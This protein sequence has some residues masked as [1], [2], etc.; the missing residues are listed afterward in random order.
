MK[1]DKKRQTGE[2][3]TADV[4][5]ELV[6]YIKD[7]QTADI[8]PSDLNDQ[9]ILSLP[10]TIWGANLDYEK[11]CNFNLESNEK[12][13]LT[14]MEF[15]TKDGETVPNCTLR[16]YDED[17][18][19]PL[20]EISQNNLWTGKKDSDVGTNIIVEINNDNNETQ[21]CMVYVSGTII[22]ED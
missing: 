13:R 15:N 6:N 22:E 9:V 17:R 18:G 20:Q 1:W 11:I 3:I 19:L 21:D 5:N 8:D 14:R 7:L 16:V 4:W 12:F 2:N 10:Y